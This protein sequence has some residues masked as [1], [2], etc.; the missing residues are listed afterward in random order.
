VRGLQSAL[1][2]LND[3][4][5]T[6]TLLTELLGTGV[7]PTRHKK[8][9]GA[10]DRL[11]QDCLEKYRAYWHQTWG[12]Q[13]YREKLLRYLAHPPRQRPQKTSR[14]EAAADAA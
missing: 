2:D 1:G 3:C 6:R 13:D 5:S 8:L 10:L 14:S 12:T 7:P 11:E 9:F 4:C